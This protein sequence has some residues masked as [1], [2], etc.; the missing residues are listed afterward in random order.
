LNGQVKSA[1]VCRGG[2]LSDEGNWAPDLLDAVQDET[3]SGEPLCPVLIIQ[4]K[5]QY[6]E[7]D[8]FCV[9]LLLL[10]TA[11][12]LSLVGSCPYTSTDKTRRI[13]IHKRNN[14]KSSTNNKKHSKYKY[15]YYQNTHTL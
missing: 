8:S 9:L 1:L 11:I 13:N 4:P 10:L 2:S 5:H 12:E 6:K 3:L 14:T 15:T 7:V